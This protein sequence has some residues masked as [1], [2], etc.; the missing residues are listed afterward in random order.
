MGARVRVRQRKKIKKTY[1]DQVFSFCP[2]FKGNVSPCKTR[3][4][5]GV[6]G[7]GRGGLVSHK[8][9]K[10]TGLGVNEVCCGP[11]PEPGEVE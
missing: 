2:L 6:L 3:D 4:G 5:G 1:K 9:A 8:E 7:R 11:P 10:S